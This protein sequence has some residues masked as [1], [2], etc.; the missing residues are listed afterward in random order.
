MQALKPRR[1][2]INNYNVGLQPARLYS[3]PSLSP[4]VVGNIG[5]SR[6]NLVKQFE[7][8]VKQ[9]STSPFAVNNLTHIENIRKEYN[10]GDDQHYQ[11]MG[12]IGGTLGVL[13]GAAFATG[14][15]G[16]Q[17]PLKNVSGVSPFKGA[18]YKG[19]NWQVRS[20]FTTSKK[21]NLK[22]QSRNEFFYGDL[23]Q[24]KLIK[25]NLGIVNSYNATTKILQQANEAYT[26]ASEGLK[27][28]T[29]NLNEAQKAWDAA[30]H[31]G[32]SKDAT[33]IAAKEAAKAQWEAAKQAEKV[34]RESVETSAEAVK[35]ATMKATVEAQ[36]LKD[37]GVVNDA[38][39]VG[40][41]VASK[42]A[43]ALKVAGVAFDVLSLGLDSYGL[44]QALEQ[45][46][47]LNSILYGTSVLGDALSVAGGIISM[48]GVGATVGVPLLI[49]GAILSIGP[50]LVRSFLVGKTVGHSLTPEGLKAQQLFAENLYASTIQRPVSTLATATWMIGFPAMLSHLGKDITKKQ[51]NSLWQNSLLRQGIRVSSKWLTTTHSGNLVRTLGSSQAMRG[52]NLLTDKADKMLPW[53]P[54][55]PR[56]VNFVTALSV[57]GDI[58]D[59]LY[60]AT[61]RK[62]LLVGMA[63]GS[64]KMIEAMARSW[65]FSK[66]PFKSVAFD[67]IRQ[68]LGWDLTPFGNSIFSSLGEILIDPQNSYEMITKMAHEKAYL[69]LT[70]AFQEYTEKA[71]TKITLQ[72]GKVVDSFDELLA[73]GGMLNGMHANEYAQIV[74]AFLNAKDFEAFKEFVVN[75]Y[76]S[77]QRGTFGE[78]GTYTVSRDFND[79]HVKQVY[80]ILTD[81][82]TKGVM[83]LTTSNDNLD[84]VRKNFKEY[85]DILDKYG[86]SG[87]EGLT[88]EEDTVLQDAQAMLMQLKEYYARKN[89]LIEDEELVEQFI[90]DFSLTVGNQEVIGLYNNSS[91]LRDHVE[92]VNAFAGIVTTLTNPTNKIVAGVARWAMRMNEWSRS[93]VA[94]KQ[95]QNQM[96]H[97]DDLYNS[98]NI[99]YDSKQ[100][101]DAEKEYN[102]KMEPVREQIKK[103]NKVSEDIV[104]DIAANVKQ[105]INAIEQ[106]YLQQDEIINKLAEQLEDKQKELKEQRE[107]YIYYPQ[108]YT[109]TTGKTIHI[110]ES[111]LA[112]KQAEI[113]SFEMGEQGV[114]LTKE[115][116]DAKINFLKKGTDADKDVVMN[117]LY[118]KTA[119]DNYTLYAKGMGALETVA[120]RL[121]EAVLF[122]SKISATMQQELNDIIN[123]VY[124][125]QHFVN[126]SKPVL[127][128]DILT[129]LIS[130]QEK[131]KTALEAEIKEERESRTSYKNK[132]KKVK[133]EIKAHEKVISDLKDNLN[134]PE[135]TPEA[136]DDV[137]AKLEEANTKLEVLNKKQKGYENDHSNTLAKI[138]ELQI[139]IKKSSDKI[140][141]WRAEKK[142]TSEDKIEYRLKYMDQSEY[143]EFYNAL[144]GDPD[145]AGGTQRTLNTKMLMAAYGIEFEMILPK[146]L[147]KLGTQDV[148]RDKQKLSLKFTYD[149]TQAIADKVLSLIGSNDIDSMLNMSFALPEDLTEYKWSKYT[150]Q[151]RTMIIVNMLNDA[152]FKNL[153]DR[154]AIL[155][156]EFLSEIEK[157]IT[158]VLNDKESI[159]KTIQI[160]EGVSPQTLYAYV[161]NRFIKN[162]NGKGEEVNPYIKLIKERLSSH[163]KIVEDIVKNLTG[164]EVN[165]I[166][167]GAAILYDNTVMVLS[168]M[169][170]FKFMKSHLEKD[171]TSYRGTKF[172]IFNNVYSDEIINTYVVKKLLD[173]A[174][175][176]DILSATQLF[177]EI[178]DNP[179]IKEER[180][181]IEEQILKKEAQ[182]ESEEV[183]T[184]ETIE[185]EN[186]SFKDYVN[187]K[188][189][190]KKES[191]ANVQE[192]KTK[193]TN[194]I[195]KQTGLDIA[196]YGIEKIRNIKL[197]SE[198]T[199]G[200]KD[201]GVD[202][203]FIVLQNEKED[204]FTYNK[205]KNPF[206]FKITLKQSKAITVSKN[207]KTNTIS[208][209]KLM[210]KENL[211]TSGH[212]EY[213]YRLAETLAKLVV[214]GKVEI[215]EQLPP[216]GI[217]TDGNTPK[218]VRIKAL[219]TQIAKAYLHGMPDNKELTFILKEVN[220]D[221][222]KKAYVNAFD[223]VIRDYMR[224]T[225]DNEDSL[226]DSS[227]FT[228]KGTITKKGY[229]AFLKKLNELKTKDIQRF[230][231]IKKLLDDY[232]NKDISLQLNSY[233]VSMSSTQSI[234]KSVANKLFMYE[235]KDINALKTQNVMVAPDVVPKIFYTD[236]RAYA[237]LDDM[238]NLENLAYDPKSSIGKVIRIF[239]K[240]ITEMY[241]DKKDINFNFLKKVNQDKQGNFT[242]TFSTSETETED[243]SL[244]D[245]IMGYKMPIIT[246]YKLVR[247]AGKKGAY[248]TDNEADILKMQQALHQQYFTIMDTYGS[249]LSRNI[250]NVNEDI[251][252]QAAAGETPE[253]VERIIKIL[254]DPVLATLYNTFDFLPTVKNK[255]MR[256]GSKERSAYQ[257][258][259]ELINDYTYFIYEQ[260]S[261]NYKKDTITYEYRDNNNKLQTITLKKDESDNENTFNLHLL[262]TLLSN[263]PK[264]ASKKEAETIRN[265]ILKNVFFYDVKVGKG[266]A[267]QTSEAY[268]EQSIKDMQEVLNEK[269]IP[270]YTRKYLTSKIKRFENV[271][272]NIKSKQGKILH[273]NLKGQ[274]LVDFLLSNPE[275]MKSSFANFIDTDSSDYVHVKMYLTDDKGNVL[276]DD[277]G[278]NKYTYVL[279]RK[280]DIESKNSNVKDNTKGI[281]NRN[282]EIINEIF[283]PLST[284]KEKEVYEKIKNKI[285]ADINKS[286]TWKGFVKD[287]FKIQASDKGVII[288]VK[289][290]ESA[291]QIL[292]EPAIFKKELGLNANDNMYVVTEK[293][294]NEIEE[295]VKPDGKVTVDYDYVTTATKAEDVTGYVNHIINFKSSKVILENFISTLV[296][297]NK[298]AQKRYKDTK[299]KNK[300]DALMKEMAEY[301]EI[302]TRVPYISKAYVEP[303]GLNYTNAAKRLSQQAK[304][305]LI[306]HK[307]INT[308]GTAKDIQEIDLTTIFKY[309]FKDKY[310]KKNR[311]GKFFELDKL[312]QEDF[313]KNDVE[314]EA[315][316]NTEI[317]KIKVIDR[318]KNALEVLQ[319][320]T[321]IREDLYENLKMDEHAEFNIPKSFIE[322]LS[323]LKTTLNRSIAN[324]HKL[325][326]DVFGATAKEMKKI[327]NSDEI[328]TITLE[329]LVQRKDMVFSYLSEFLAEVD[330]YS[331]ELVH[332]SKENFNKDMHIKWDKNKIEALKNLFRG[333][334]EDAERIEAVLYLKSKSLR[335]FH[336]KRVNTLNSETAYIGKQHINYKMVFGLNKLFNKL[337]DNI[338]KNG[339]STFELPTDV[340]KI[341][342]ELEAYLKKL[343]KTLWKQLQKVGALKNS[344][345]NAVINKELVKL[346][347]D[348]TTKIGTDM[349]SHMFS[350]DTQAMIISKN[351]EGIKRL[352]AYG[353]K[354]EDDLY[355]AIVFD[356]VTYV[357]DAVIDE[358]ENSRV[359]NII[360]EANDLTR[361]SIK[362]RI[363]AQGGVFE[364]Y[365]KTP[366]YKKEFDATIQETFKQLTKE[367]KNKKYKKDIKYTRH[368]LELKKDTYVELDSAYSVL[369]AYATY[370][371]LYDPEFNSEDYINAYDSIHELMDVV[372]D[373]FFTNQYKFKVASS[374][375]EEATEGDD[376]YAKQFTSFDAY[377]DSLPEGDRKLIELFIKAHKTGEFDIEL[378]KQTEYFTRLVGKTGR[379][380]EGFVKEFEDI[381][382]NK[383]TA[384][385]SALAKKR[386]IKNAKFKDTA[387]M[388]NL[389]R[390]PMLDNNKEFMIYLRNQIDGMKPKE[391]ELFLS[392]IGVEGQ[393]LQNMLKQYP[394]FYDFALQISKHINSK[395]DMFAF[396]QVTNAYKQ[397]F[398]MGRT[399]EASQYD[400]FSWKYAH[401]L[402][403]EDE[404]GDA[405]E[406]IEITAKNMFNDK[407]KVF[408]SNLIASVN[409]STAFL[410][411]IL[412]FTGKTNTILNN[413]IFDKDFTTHYG[414]HGNFL[415]ATP[416]QTIT[417]VKEIYTD[418]VSNIF[419]K[420]Y[421][422]YVGIGM[423]TR[424]E[425]EFGSATSDYSAETY[426]KKLSEVGTHNRLY[427]TIRERFTDVFVAIQR[428]EFKEEEFIKLSEVA[429]AIGEFHR[430]PSI[431]KFYLNQY[432]VYVASLSMTK[433]EHEAYTK[434]VDNLIDFWKSSDSFVDSDDGTLLKAALGYVMASRGLVFKNEEHFKKEMI[435]YSKEYIKA[436]ANLKTTQINSMANKLLSAKNVNEISNIIYGKPFKELP[437]TKQ[438]ELTHIESLYNFINHSGKLSK[439]NLY[440]TQD[441]TNDGTQKA[442]S[443][444]TTHTIERRRLVEE[445]DRVLKVKEELEKQ[446]DTLISGLKEDFEDKLKELDKE[447]KKLRVFSKEKKESIEKDIEKTL[448][449]IEKNKKLF[450]KT[451]D[452]TKRVEKLEKRLEDNEVVVKEKQRLLDEI[453]SIKK[454][455]SSL[456]T[457]KTDENLKNAQEKAKK[458]VEY[459]NN[460]LAHVE[461]Q[462]FKEQ[463]LYREHKKEFIGALLNNHPVLFEAVLKKQEEEQ[464]ELKEKY[465]KAL[466]YV[467][468][469]KH[470]PPQFIALHEKLTKE[471]EELQAFF[472]T[473]AYKIYVLCVN[474]VTRKKDLNRAFYNAFK[475]DFRK[476]GVNSY[477]ESYRAWRDADTKIKE[478]NARLEEINKTEDYEVE[479]TRKNGEKYT[480]KRKYKS[481]VQK[482]EK[483]LKTVEYEKEAY[484]K[485]M[486]KDLFDEDGIAIKEAEA[487]LKEVITNFENSTKKSYKKFIQGEI[488]SSLT[489]KQRDRIYAYQ[490]QQRTKL[491]IGHKKTVEQLKKLGYPS[492]NVEAS[493]EQIRRDI[494]SLNIGKERGRYMSLKD[495]LNKLISY[496]KADAQIDN[497]VNK[498]KNIPTTQRFNLILDTY[499]E[500]LAEKDIYIDND[501]IL[502]AKKVIEAYRNYATATNKAKDSTA[503]TMR[504]GY[505]TPN[506]NEAED[507]IYTLLKYLL[508]DQ[509]N[510][511]AYRDE[512][513][514]MSRV[515]LKEEYNAIRDEIKKF[516]KYVSD[517][518]K[519]FGG[520]GHKS[521]ADQLVEVNDELDKLNHDVKDAETKVKES[522]EAFIK[523]REISNSNVGTLKK[524]YPALYG[525]LTDE[526]IIDEVIKNTP[527]T[528]EEDIEEIITKGG[529][530]RELH[531]DVIDTLITN[532][533]YRAQ[534][535][536]RT[537]VVPEKYFVIDM[538]TLPTNMSQFTP[539]SMTVLIVEQ[540]AVKR[541]LK[542]HINNEVFI[543][544]MELEKGNKIS[545][546]M[547]VYVERFYQ[548]QLEIEKSK[549]PKNK[550]LTVDDIKPDVIEM[551]K[552]LAKRPNY[553]ESLETI[554]QLISMDKNTPIVAH[555]GTKF[556]FPL[557]DITMKNL[558]QRTLLSLYYDEI[559]KHKLQDV[560]KRYKESYTGS[561]SKIDE[562]E[563]LIRMLTQEQQELIALAN[564]GKIETPDQI[565]A[566]REINRAIRAFKITQ[567]IENARINMGN[568][569]DEDLRESLITGENAKLK[570]AHRY[571]AEYLVKTNLNEK[572]KLRTKLYHLLVEGV[573]TQSFD[574]NNKKDLIKE[575]DELL[576]K[577]T[578]TFEELMN[579]GEITYGVTD[580]DLS[581]DPK[582]VEEALMRRFDPTNERRIKAVTFKPA[583]NIKSY[584]ETINDIDQRIKALK[585][586]DGDNIINMRD[587]LE[588]RKITLE[589]N[590]KVLEGKL[591]ELEGKLTTSQKAIQT[592]FQEIIDFAKNINTK[593]ARPIYESN[594]ILRNDYA[595]YVK[596]KNI[597][598]DFIANESLLRYELRAITRSMTMELQAIE[599]IKAYSSKLKKD[600][601][602]N[603]M[604]HD[605]YKDFGG[606][607]S[608]R[609]QEDKN[610]LLKKVNTQINEVITL[611][612]SLNN[613]ALT[614]KFG[615]KKFADSALG[616][617]IVQNVLTSLSRNIKETYTE[618]K[619]LWNIKFEDNK[620]PELSED[621][622]EQALD[623]YN[624][625]IKYN[626][627]KLDPNNDKD[628]RILTMLG[629]QNKFI[630][631]IENYKDFKSPAVFNDLD[632]IYDLIDVYLSQKQ[633]LLNSTK[634]TIESITPNT[635][636][637]LNITAI[638]FLYNKYI[639]EAKNIT[640]IDKLARRDDI[641][642]ILGRRIKRSRDMIYD[643]EKGIDEQS[644]YANRKQAKEFIEA[645]GNPDI[646]AV[647]KSALE[648]NDKFAIRQNPDFFFLTDYLLDDGSTLYTFSTYDPINQTVQKLSVSSGSPEDINIEVTYNYTEVSRR[649]NKPKAIKAWMSNK[650]KYDNYGDKIYPKNFEDQFNDLFS[651]NPEVNIKKS[652]R[653]DIIVLT[654]GKDA[655]KESIKKLIDFA[656]EHIDVKTG[657]FDIDK[658]KA[659]EDVAYDLELPAKALV[660]VNL[661]REL[662]N[663]LADYLDLLEI[664]R[665]GDKFEDI[666]KIYVGLYNE[667]FSKFNALEDGKVLNQIHT[668]FSQ[669][670]VIK[671]DPK[672]LQEFADNQGII[673]DMSSE[674]SAG[675]TF[676]LRSFYDMK[677]PFRQNTHVT[678][679]LLSLQKLNALFTPIKINNDYFEL[680]ELDK[681]KALEN[682]L[683]KYDDVY[684]N[685]FMYIDGLK[686]GELAA[687][688]AE[689]AEKARQL[690]DLSAG[691]AKYL[692]KINPFV[693]ATL[694]QDMKQSYDRNIHHKVGINLQVG[695]ANVA[696]AHEDTVL[697]DFD[698]AMALGIKE[699]NKSWLGLMY[700]FKGAIKLKK[701]LRAEYGV[702]IIAEHDSI[703]GRGS[704][705]AVLEMAISNL[706]DI[707]IG[708]YSDSDK[709]FSNIYKYIT[710]NKDKI[711]K[712]FGVKKLEDLVNDDG[713]IILDPYIDYDKLFKDNG[714][715]VDQM[716][717]ATASTKV[718]G[719]E[720]NFAAGRLYV[721]LDPKNTADK[722]ATEAKVNSVGDVEY[723]LKTTKG[724]YDSGVVISPTVVYTMQAKG[725]TE[726]YKVF[727][728]DVTPLDKV[729]KIAFKGIEA[730]FSKSLTQRISEEKLKEILQDNVYGLF[731]NY[732]NAYVTHHNRLV[733]GNLSE[734]DKIFSEYMLH[735]IERRMRNE[736]L[737]SISS[738]SGFYYNA[739]Y[740]KHPGIRRQ[741]VANLELKQG[742]LK[743]PFDGF[744]ALINMREDFLIN[745]KTNEVISKADLN[746]IK[747]KVQEIDNIKE[748]KDDI[749]VKGALL[750]RYLKENFADYFGR[751]LTLR[752][753]VQDYNAS[754]IMSI[755]G[756]SEHHA[757]ESTPY[758]Y[759]MIGG[760]NDGDTIGMAIVGKK[761]FDDY[762]TPLDATKDEYYDEGYIA[763]IAKKVVPKDKDSQGLLNRKDNDKF[764]EK[765]LR[766]VN[767]GKNTFGN[768]NIIRKNFTWYEIYNHAFEDNKYFK[769]ALKNIPQVSLAINDENISKVALY[770]NA[771]IRTITGGE[772]L[773][774]DIFDISLYKDLSTMKALIEK[775]EK[776]KH[777][778]N[779]IYS[780]DQAILKN[781]LD[782][783]SFI[784]ADDIN[785][786]YNSLLPEDKAYIDR[787][788]PTLIIADKTSQEARA[789]KEKIFFEKVY[790]NLM[791]GGVQRI[792]GSKRGVG[793]MGGARKEQQVASLVSI[794]EEVNKTYVPADPAKGI[795][796][797]NYWDAEGYT[798]SAGELTIRSIMNGLGKKFGNIF[799]S[800]SKYQETI[801]KLDEKNVT[802]Q[803]IEFVKKQLDIADSV[804][805][806]FEGLAKAINEK[807]YFGLAR[808]IEDLKQNVLDQDPML[809]NFLDMLKEKPSDE[810]LNDVEETMLAIILFG[811]FNSTFEKFMSVR[812]NEKELKKFTDK[813]RLAFIDQFVIGR[814]ELKA[815]SDNATL[816]I[817]M[818]K[819]HGFDKNASTFLKKYSDDVKKSTTLKGIQ[820]TNIDDDKHILSTSI[821]MDKN[822]IGKKVIGFEISKEEKDLLKKLKTTP[823]KDPGKFSS[824]AIAKGYLEQ[825][826]RQE[827]KYTFFGNSAVPDDSYKIVEDAAIELFKAFNQERDV[828]RAIKL[829]RD[830]TAKGEY[831]ENPIET[832]IRNDVPFYRVKEALLSSYTLLQFIS[833]KSYMQN[834]H[835]VNASDIPF[836]ANAIYAFESGLILK[837]PE[838][839]QILSQNSD[840]SREVQWLLNTSHNDLDKMEIDPE[841]GEAY[842]ANLASAYYKNETYLKDTINA[843]IDR[844]KTFIYDR[845][846]LDDVF[847]LDKLN[848]NPNKLFIEELMKRLKYIPLN[849]RE[850]IEDLLNSTLQNIETLL[851]LYQVKEG[852]IKEI[853]DK[854][855]PTTTSLK[856]AFTNN[857]IYNYYN[858]ADEVSNITEKHKDIKEYKDQINE[859]QR[860]LISVKSS[861]RNNKHETDA[862]NASLAYPKEQ[863]TKA[864]LIKR[865]EERKAT[866]QKDLEEWQERIK[867]YAISEHFAPFIRYL[868]VDDK[869]IFNLRT[870]NQDPKPLTNMD[871]GRI[872]QQ[873]IMSFAQNQTPFL[874]ILS[875]YRIRNSQGTDI[876]YDWNAMFRWYKKAYG[877]LRLTYVGQGDHEEEGL[878]RTIHNV[879]RKQNVEYN[880]LNNKQQK[881]ID[882]YA[883]EHPGIVGDDGI[884]NYSGLPNKDVR[885]LRRI[886]Y[887]QEHFTD[888]KYRDGELE[889][890]KLQA[891]D[892]GR[893]KNNPRM[894]VFNGKTYKGIAKEGKG[895]DDFSLEM[896]RHVSPVLTEIDI[897]SP[898]DLRKVFEYINKSKDQTIPLIGFTYRNDYMTAMNL[899]YK[900]FNLAGTKLD[901]FIG[902]LERQAKYLMRL[903]PGFLLRNFIETW[904]Q[905]YSNAFHKFGMGGMIMNRKQIFNIMTD[906]FKIFSLYEDLSQELVLHKA[907]LNA[908]FN[909]AKIIL[910]KDLKDRS[911]ANKD[912]LESII[913]YLYYELD[914]WG[915]GVDLISTKS[916][917]IKHREKLYK[918]HMKIFKNYM[919]NLQDPK[920]DKNIILNKVSMQEIEDATLFLLRTRFGEFYSV[921]QEIAK[922]IEA[923]NIRHTNSKYYTKIKKFNKNLPEDKIEATRTILAELSYFMETEAQTDMYKMETSNWLNEY[924]NTRLHADANDIDDYSYEQIM[925]DVEKIKKQNYDTLAK[926]VLGSP[927][928]LYD[929]IN[930]HI[931]NTSRVAQ[932]LYDR[933]LYNMNMKQTV[934]DSLSRWFNYG[935]RSPQEMRLTTDIPYMSFPVRSIMNWIERL[936]N[937]AYLRMLSD[938]VDGVYSQYRDEDGRYNEYTIF[939]IQQ[940]WIPISKN[941]GMRFGR[942]AFDVLNLLQDPAGNIEQRT[943]PWIQALRAS[944]GGFGEMVQKLAFA[945]QARQILNAGTALT[946][947]RK[948]AQETPVVKNFVNKKPA[949]LGTSL[950]IFYDTGYSAGQ[951]EYG[952]YTPKYYRQQFSNGR[953]QR[954]ENIYKEWFNKY[955]RMR[956]PKVDPMSLVKDIQWKTYVRWKRQDYYRKYGY[957][958]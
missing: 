550:N 66:E 718:K 809:V 857:A 774:K 76:S 154:E 948:L 507:A 668:D 183:I 209:G 926:L 324:T 821:A 764:G 429:Q 149:K 586:L 94:N 524:L 795:K 837:A 450:K 169:H 869:S 731:Q 531:N 771:A 26:V 691:N 95:R 939:Q 497:N 624:K 449:E 369:D 126:A 539:Y 86:K 319:E 415:V 332:S 923:G 690:L 19:S 12:A 585:E 318:I 620:L 673:L 136:R 456:S 150:T 448:K 636:E 203:F 515:D 913:S 622:P 735:N 579:G 489:Q 233:N 819:H 753:P 227:M 719:K 757:V 600:D 610:K 874:N 128:K 60:G 50:T 163:D 510:Y 768:R 58:N 411:D 341:P 110:S 655:S 194:D 54:D 277:L 813:I 693:P 281:P 329:E 951:Y 290:K 226:V 563:I 816:I 15:V 62:S 178:A 677:L 902:K 652:A 561:M 42:G 555:N 237:L 466:E 552:E 2:L 320:D 32:R 359:D 175:K 535:L 491:E 793:I 253:E 936:N 64:E 391:R 860:K 686:D 910:N 238:A 900:T 118:T 303:V 292:N 400:S 878:L 345:D 670:F 658:A 488:P 61:E 866:Y 313:V 665:R 398:A 422:K 236:E 604:G 824:S 562:S 315:F 917:R 828:I 300:I 911:E 787:S 613:S 350:N 830:K 903:T 495:L 322:T 818:A 822:V 335:E 775:D 121:H 168:Q 523:D 344:Y 485:A 52:L 914:A 571:M 7:Y 888:K 153:E 151:E 871:V 645:M 356:T 425:R 211:D 486:S 132:I 906:T 333:S 57:Y 8:T 186:R 113:A 374:Q 603:L 514:V 919:F 519:Y 330:Y 526:E 576:A 477:E 117:Y 261:K 346:Y 55:D 468:N 444:V 17:A 801:S 419:K 157:T 751:V 142:K 69:S 301:D 453:N 106:E 721:M 401:K 877:D 146:D 96:K 389:L 440:D 352:W 886:L 695:F 190:T 251:M 446:A 904:D 512:Q 590:E 199:G 41:E 496:K 791:Q 770:L 14:R 765:D 46:D 861:L 368:V 529:A 516:S 1:S 681:D 232:I 268:I 596:D 242:F 78:T 138:S 307:F 164:P 938:I 25:D 24:Q 451:D 27:V 59:N 609:T 273:G 740:T 443:R 755:V 950:N 159:S 533:N 367:Y 545:P 67:D 31:V 250:L 285:I 692:Y 385:L 276:K 294:F 931:E 642:N 286:P 800:H 844:I 685:D 827:L 241:K 469:P 701:G 838:E 218:D 817:A 135:L 646:K 311:E 594:R 868:T 355:K 621:A 541:I 269:K 394:T 406:G 582:S 197:F 49:A 726:W 851:A 143:T 618:I 88:P 842:N 372:Q 935:Q 870:R 431:T 278:H 867:E 280:D 98:A 632:G 272:T 11:M 625:Q 72:K 108:K 426:A 663:K 843:Q 416:H 80:E 210:D 420:S 380:K 312:M 193:V 476:L 518:D 662:K 826:L 165:E 244:F 889:L 140:T 396:I 305:M 713:Q 454:S 908:R 536:K 945:G 36:K 754:P 328:R 365:N 74:K 6:K 270:S 776:V 122:M 71:K 362:R 641:F 863:Q 130:K 864:N 436:Y 271:L 700:G 308:M 807:D 633:T 282:I 493:I 630:R 694:T 63:G 769:E 934:T 112:N 266:K 584:M 97:I 103:V 746:K 252:R 338:I 99:I 478:I 785:N 509:T 947:T 912:T 683:T 607:F 16:L 445:R 240:H 279:V 598:Q 334:N 73:E 503:N 156:P 794:F 53:A 200:Y 18:F 145:T 568:G 343:S 377:L 741:L 192:V 760:D 608:M 714:L 166:K 304:G 574:S 750:Q 206:L 671:Y 289:D 75:I 198:H 525:N 508:Y 812:K 158:E 464:K 745:R 247:E 245:L 853:S 116:L 667:M 414:K 457:L 559:N 711:L 882:R 732:L 537:G 201:E 893:Y 104:D 675:T 924:I 548:Q 84:Q 640:D 581:K 435:N 114:K 361:R 727:K 829:L 815:I 314:L 649:M 267:S 263:K 213:V 898:D 664:A 358:I 796:G 659:R 942:G 763:D 91:D 323:Q 68:E 588:Q 567:A 473:P 551:V 780:F 593:I 222:Y 772:D 35:Q 835:V 883:K 20:P 696:D 944:D 472:K 65:G 573:E 298:Q 578:V 399:R 499:I 479:S 849:E 907:E 176:G 339:I 296:D 382:S 348:M 475:E 941:T 803:I 421:R 434:A 187:Q 494:K 628:I 397:Y 452:L 295:M 228:P 638:N 363:E 180:K 811:R 410:Y 349:P 820:H 81:I 778:F 894:L 949:S 29:T 943:A 720:Y 748:L 48:T 756:I 799:S 725:V 195:G 43:T 77:T 283:N 684:V 433:K 196:K 527:Y 661:S 262:L 927:T 884:V 669:G 229:R 957:F 38:F 855:I 660:S 327:L 930:G 480:Y 836:L 216:T 202:P 317:N 946:G 560:R 614:F 424:F 570:Q 90:N 284:D 3:R 287:N 465:T 221:A 577:I 83:P 825:L 413:A 958:R 715:D 148:S 956:K 716:V 687:K 733:D 955:G 875:F 798:N 220:D 28:A 439:Y 133:E 309:F 619:N 697:M 208:Y 595:A 248:K 353:I 814:Q 832:L 423:G 703:S 846:Y 599:N 806:L 427:Q 459:L 940:G 492:D 171:K 647:W 293:T 33:R 761:D 189:Q 805:T 474:S 378:F 207:R 487:F 438:L 650:V 928:R 22:R 219:A 845:S 797:Y 256:D 297:I 111:N 288:A 742:E 93:N 575:I 897:T 120:S 543:A 932:F 933:Y 483:A 310:I 471:K 708:H 405:Y 553:V 929:Y 484:D 179:V 230:Y 666:N 105:E 39:V 137:T 744:K 597:P 430:A 540:G 617:E 147:K 134:S 264:G 390:L 325:A 601:L 521:N 100:V 124:T 773:H 823:I 115:Q 447:Y 513:G 409:E 852:K 47:T 321:L 637:T 782:M 205:L 129:D 564:Q 381:H 37:V 786:Y 418:L 395:A 612:E 458:R 810:V 351:L 167:Q 566:M 217:F 841:T 840:Y 463:K 591:H 482:Y 651:S 710:D 737:Q 388:F 370:S 502:N 572:S 342:K 565:E 839:Q 762:L 952:K 30:K 856:I 522:N 215:R 214:E 161:R 880:E 759:K 56:D 376:E 239:N 455:A 340:F 734:K 234:L 291:K 511:R 34:A 89:M 916:N 260:A 160:G 371:R 743:V 781:E 144:M 498:L 705:G 556:D 139:K 804:P 850:P 891:D 504:D 170:A 428:K 366:E 87:R 885:Y 375:E 834:G 905:H 162:K 709:N 517:V 682:L 739:H 873:R 354:S 689:R 155:R 729:S 674:G 937:P 274:T 616:K 204:K 40:K 379:D 702:S 634:A 141:A 808:I 747:N 615:D 417:T 501:K 554:V 722:M 257:K 672:S 402:F 921:Q 580:E 534:M 70:S 736:A 442:E 505:N 876:D 437:A 643:P 360:R 373:H 177:R 393:Q 639:S 326:K 386:K 306:I 392:Y 790:S 302:I 337:E 246:L 265:D 460:A 892:L 384:V 583:E 152:N 481:T 738:R 125:F 172:S 462:L 532:Q 704:Y 627:K 767:V 173:K 21:F 212:T 546:D 895:E 243:L 792:Q 51:A 364:D 82:V 231:N 698:D 706:K 752:S 316:L 592:S 127:K 611:R 789:I 918:Q 915:Q 5:A 657:K 954:Y 922:H 255:T 235:Q 605:L 331:N 119:V 602:K 224:E 833:Q 879:V 587:E 258:A 404:L 408:E 783:V 403:V 223:K 680:E 854:E 45:E 656:K 13:G 101:E 953:Y 730:L 865:L 500:T 766:F 249:F 724:A 432:N 909:D 558:S 184:E 9:L 44:Y 383:Y 131:T 188:E 707:I 881:I 699:G 606:M 259:P 299:E 654:D 717:N 544:I 79:L 254:Q 862:V 225:R 623:I 412:S 629:H 712:T 542:T 528:G 547:Q 557:F 644:E 4:L 728:P 779:L 589:E 123:I 653:Q 831:T 920:V 85:K 777:L 679:T 336:K 635:P 490:K 723:V 549:D 631:V 749:A 109:F 107:K 441:Y 275:L 848:K 191:K 407:A 872:R 538:E 678:R 347:T 648:G 890:M 847:D 899:S 758:L 626:L 788:K 802:R 925:E 467:N 901:N 896:S 520:S 569:V 357:V 688:K 92:L 506:S 10:I 181:R 676:T 174:A 858:I 102:A 470:F 185:P 23:K 387:E 784:E 182:I 887:D 461:E 530:K 859:I